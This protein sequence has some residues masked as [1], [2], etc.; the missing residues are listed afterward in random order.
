VVVGFVLAAVGL[1]ARFLDS[2]SSGARRK[3]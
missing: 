1:L 3:E 2:T